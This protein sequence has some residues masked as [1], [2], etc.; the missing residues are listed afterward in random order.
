MTGAWPFFTG[1]MSQT[2]NGQVGEPPLVPHVEPALPAKSSARSG[3]F[4][5]SQRKNSCVLT[6]NW[7]SSCGLVALSPEM[8]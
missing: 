6:S 5:S 8:S 1:E 2:E 3:L 4:G 7:L